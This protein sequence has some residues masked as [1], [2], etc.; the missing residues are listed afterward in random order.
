MSDT[1]MTAQKRIIIETLSAMTSH[2]TATMVYEE[3]KGKYPTISRATVFRVLNQLAEAKIIRRVNIP[4]SD[5]R[6]DFRTE[7]H[8]H[9]KC[10]KC[11]AVGDIFT[12]P[13]DDLY[14]NIEDSCGYNVEGFDIEFLGICKNCKS[15]K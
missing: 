11:G 6:Y 8:Y 3:I 7:E 12:K 9:I 15:K 10:V 5:D 13:L 14:E 4:Q 1:R 2:P